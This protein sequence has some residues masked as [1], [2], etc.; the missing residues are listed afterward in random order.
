MSI[1]ENYINVKSVEIF[2]RESGK[3]LDNRRGVV[4]LLHGQ[5]FSSLNW[6]ENSTLKKLAEWNFHAIAIDLPG[7]L[8]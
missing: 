5:K 2:Y 1:S 3:E 7:E 6:K 8:I 4:L